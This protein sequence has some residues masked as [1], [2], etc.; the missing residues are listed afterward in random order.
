MKVLNGATGVDVTPEN[1]A[2]Q[3]GGAGGPVHTGRTLGDILVERRSV[4]EDQVA[5]AMRA[6]QA[7]DHRRIVEILEQQAGLD[8]H[9]GIDAGAEQNRL[10]ICACRRATPQP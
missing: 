7:G 9:T 4:T 3:K 5:D 1:E 8:E 2:P 6:K 10:K